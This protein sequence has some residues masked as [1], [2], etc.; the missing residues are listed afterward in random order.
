LS[1]VIALVASMPSRP[2]IRRSITT[3]SGCRVSAAATASAPSETSAL[4][5]MSGCAE[6]SI[7]IP[8]RTIGWSS[9]RTTLIGV[10][11]S[12]LTRLVP[13]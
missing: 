5:S 8:A 4:T 6:S 13:P 10:G 1:A 12:A 11:L 9:A 3:M 2:G 7:A